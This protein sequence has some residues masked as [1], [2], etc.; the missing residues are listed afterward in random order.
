MGGEL[1]PNRMFSREGAQKNLWKLNPKWDPEQVN[2]ALDRLDNER[3]ALVKALTPPPGGLIVAL[4]NNAHGYSMNDEIP[5]SDKTA[6]NDASHPHE[7][8]LCTDPADFDRL[9]KGAVQRAAA[10][11]GTAGR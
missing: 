11:V 10:E 7:F 4:H 1:D 8:I 5:I 3:P 2:R 6:L 9:A